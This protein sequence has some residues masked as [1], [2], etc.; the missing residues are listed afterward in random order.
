LVVDGNA[1]AGALRKITEKIK[2]PDVQ[3]LTPIYADMQPKASPGQIAGKAQ[4][5][6]SLLN[7]QGADLIVVLID[8]E[9]RRDCQGVFAKDLERAFRKRGHD[10]V[11]VVVKKVM[12][13]NWL[14]A[15]VDALK[16]VPGRFKPTKGFE[17][18]VAPN[19]AD[20]V[21]DPCR[22]LNSIALGSKRYHKRTDATAV[23]AHCRPKEMARNS[24]SFRRFL[25][26]LG[27]PLYQDQS[28]SP[29]T[30]APRKR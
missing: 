13:E 19:K 23:A 27:H 17:R 22:L 8:L 10:D 29:P 4:P 12:F 7:G 15:D 25:R 9:D 16:A 6:L 3:L 21:S 11:F 2:V 1:E 24:R 20:S 28:L 18:A 5:R 14:I 30:R 26:V